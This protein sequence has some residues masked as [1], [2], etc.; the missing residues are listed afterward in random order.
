[1]CCGATAYKGNWND[2]RKTNTL[3]YVC[4]CKQLFVWKM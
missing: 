1:M 2:I 4:A 3:P